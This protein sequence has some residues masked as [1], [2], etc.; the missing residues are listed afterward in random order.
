VQALKA[1][2]SA[3]DYGGMVQ[4]IRR[5]MNVQVNLKLVWTSSGSEDVPAWIEMPK[6]MPF[7]GSKEFHEL[8]VTMTIRKQFMASSTY[9]RA[10]IAVAHEFSHVVLN[11]LRHPLRNC[12]K[13]VDLT[14]M[15]LGFSALYA[16]GGYTETRIGNTIRQSQLGYLTSDELRAARRLLTPIAPGPKAKTHRT[17]LTARQRL[18]VIIL[19]GGSVAALALGSKVIGWSRLHDQLVARQLD[20]LK[21]LPLPLDANNGQKPAPAN[22]A[23]ARSSEPSSTQVIPLPRPRPSR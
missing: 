7:Y 9:D 22:P 8:T 19:L 13:A 16:S 20:E 4:L 1:L 6:D 15:V 2:H 5:T 10:A 21:K 14:A 12:E 3:G 23:A 18:A 11:S 17:A